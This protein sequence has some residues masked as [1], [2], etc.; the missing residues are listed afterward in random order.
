M[1]FGSDGALTI[2]A[3]QNV[4]AT[5]LKY[6]INYFL[7]SVHCVTHMTNLAAINATKMDLAK[8]YKKKYMHYKIQ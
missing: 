2:T 4:L 3:T 5:R 7:T 6:N 8:S 1:E